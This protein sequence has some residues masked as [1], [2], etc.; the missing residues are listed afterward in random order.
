MGYEGLTFMYEEG[1]PKNGYYPNLT[2]HDF[3][4]G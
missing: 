4:L 2:S 1:T 3:S